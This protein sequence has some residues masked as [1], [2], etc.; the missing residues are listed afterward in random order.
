VGKSQ[1]ITLRVS[2]TERRAIER[3]LAKQ[4]AEGR[5]QKRNA[6]TLI[7]DLLHEKARKMGLTIREPQPGGVPET[8]FTKAYPPG[9]VLFF[10]QS[11]APSGVIR[12]DSTDNITA[13]LAT[14]TREHPVPLKL[15]LSFPGDDRLKQAVQLMFAHVRARGE[16]FLPDTALLAFIAER[17]HRKPRAKPKGK[18]SE[19]NAAAVAAKLRGL[20]DIPPDPVVEVRS[21]PNDTPPTATAGHRKRR[22]VERTT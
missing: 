16:W 21:S 11:T 14:L 12:I 1:I 2:P 4:N 10:V 22:G 17:A 9:Q 18:P 7:R 8:S 13:R 20:R 3:I 19:F 6:S 5:P 15:L